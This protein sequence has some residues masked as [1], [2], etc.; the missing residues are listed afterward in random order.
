M[1]PWVR[2]L[3]HEG[4]SPTPQA[5]L[6]RAVQRQDGGRLLS[7]GE[8]PRGWEE[9]REQEVLGNLLESTSKES[10]DPGFFVPLPGS[11]GNTRQLFT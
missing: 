1:W 6:F 10:E 9:P 8:S 11:S 2:E 7:P 5:V 3:V 4:A